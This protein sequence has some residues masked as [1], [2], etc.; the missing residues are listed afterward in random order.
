MSEVIDI[1]LLKKVRDAREQ[2]KNTHRAIWVALD[3]ALAAFTLAHA[4][5]TDDFYKEPKAQWRAQFQAINKELSEAL[6]T[7][8]CYL[9]QL[10]RGCFDPSNPKCDCPPCGG[11][12]D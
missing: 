8:A 5:M 6:K 4:G 1:E 10:N 12:N 3:L 11:Y 7:L 9:D 2:S